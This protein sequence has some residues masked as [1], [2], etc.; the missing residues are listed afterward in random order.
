MV[1]AW[2]AFGWLRPAFPAEPPAVSGEAMRQPLSISG[3]EGGVQPLRL[4]LARVIGALPDTAPAGAP[5][6]PGDAAGQPLSVFKGGDRPLRLILARAI[7]GTS[8]AAVTAE[9]VD[10]PM[11]AARQPFSASREG[12][13]GVQPFRLK[14]ARAIGALPDTVPAGAPAVPGGAAGQPLSAF[15][16]EGVDDRPLRL[17][18]ARAIGAS[19][20]AA[21]VVAAA[22]AGVAVEPA[23]KRFSSLRLAPIEFVLGGSIGYD[24]QRQTIGADKYMTQ[25]LNTNVNAGANTFIWQPWFARV[26]GTLGLSLNT[27]D[28]ETSQTTSKTSN[29]IVTGKAIFSLLPSS[30]F[31]FEARFD[32]SDSRQNSSAG[33]ASSAY[34]STRYGLTQR[35]R[36]LSGDAHYMV[37]YDH[38]IWEGAS[39]D[40]NKQ[41]TLRVET[42]QQFT[43]QTLRINGDSTRNERTLTNQST[44]VNN[45]VSQHSYRPDTNFSVESLA[46]LVKANYRLTQG[47]N[48][49]DYMQLS[50]SAYWR[51]TEK[52]L[53]VNG[54]VRLSGQSSRNTAA[55][56]TT[57]QVRSANANVGANYDLSKHVRL[58]GSGNVSVIDT[59][60]AQAVS[61]NQN[62]GA[63]YQPDAI[64]F[65]AFS[66]TRS[67][68]GNVGN[69]TDSIGG[70]QHFSLSPSH[71]LNRKIGLG[72][73]TLGMNLNQ[74]ITFDVDT[75]NPSSSIL[76]HMGSLSWGLLEG[77]KTTLVH[78]SANDSRAMSGAPYSFQLVNLQASLNENLNRNA[79]W[80]GNLTAQ[81]VRQETSTT[82]SL[83]TTSS[84]ANLS[85]RHQRAFNVPRLRFTSE[86]RIF[87][88]SLVPVLAT[89]D[90]EET[91]SWENRFDYSIGRLQLR[92]SARLAEVN[93]VNQSLYW[94]NISRQF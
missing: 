7:G 27:T 1:A 31:P 67:V 57:S 24:V 13:G 9:E 12:G 10:V 87:G 84:S 32:R 11:G 75:R 44:L 35:Y 72:G 34:Q 33:V 29:N 52:P 46:N 37:S 4:K 66:Y 41:D 2:L 89:P 86:L 90:K 71:G 49:L 61:T 45:L 60:G 55:T 40:E 25:S 94:F 21:G 43:N 63:T 28:M 74:A 62:I 19:P 58:N 76:S 80:G 14:L 26:S 56:G 78:L 83:T 48:D 50:S 5:A 59:N 77:R 8:P 81:I 3:G 54:G 73:G 70:A 92:L 42:T 88:D 22:P 91:R 82:P 79:T 17:K 68:T 30:R 93:K 38:D 47:G 85:Y 64:A 20:A 23:A 36:P 6:V 15:K 69:R 18:L 53:N 16:E 65:G 39:L 51:S